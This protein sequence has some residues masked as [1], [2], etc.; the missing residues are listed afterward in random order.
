M[1]NSGSDFSNIHLLAEL[2]VSTLDS[3][4]QIDFLIWMLQSHVPIGQ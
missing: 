2:D 4:H 3:F 1:S